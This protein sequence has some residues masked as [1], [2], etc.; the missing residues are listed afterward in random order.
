MMG[1]E[2]REVGVE[3]RRGFQAPFLT[4]SL[5][6]NPLDGLWFHD[7]EDDTAHH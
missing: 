1:K 6:N 3:I 4:D 2:V 7:G 5:T